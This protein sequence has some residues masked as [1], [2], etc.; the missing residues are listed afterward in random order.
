[1]KYERSPNHGD[2]PS[3]GRVTMKL[4]TEEHSLLRSCVDVEGISGSVLARRALMTDIRRRLRRK[5][6][7]EEAIRRA[8]KST[9]MRL[10][11]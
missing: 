4:N 5:G 10:K 2:G 7:L 8:R 1:M 6:M 3:D 9:E 11:R